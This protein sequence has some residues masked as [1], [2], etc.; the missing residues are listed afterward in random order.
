MEMWSQ[1]S[2]GQWH[3]Y[4]RLLN[5]HPW[6]RFRLYVLTSATKYAPVSTGGTKNIYVSTSFD[7]AR[8]VLTSTTKNFYILT[9]FEWTIYNSTMTEENYFDQFRRRKK[10]SEFALCPEFSHKFLSF[11]QTQWSLASFAIKM[12]ILRPKY[13]DPYSYPKLHVA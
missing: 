5:E 13:C 7:Q 8:H 6:P 12:E 10:V 3:L 4:H 9:N 1:S 2:A 11:S